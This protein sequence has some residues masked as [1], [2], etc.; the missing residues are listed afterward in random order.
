MYAYLVEQANGPF[1]RVDLPH[2]AVGESDVLIRLK[3]SGVN[4]LDTKIRAGAA[5]HAKQ[6]LPAV[7]GLDMAGHGGGGRQPRHRIQ[8]WR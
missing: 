4:P 2:P 1:V 3:A 7:L 6:P 8:I 5:A